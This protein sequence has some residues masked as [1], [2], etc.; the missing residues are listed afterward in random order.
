MR[1]NF[2]FL[3]FSLLLSLEAA[4]L[5]G[6]SEPA[7]IRLF[8]S[9]VEPSSMSADHYCTVVFSD[10]RFHSEKAVLHHGKDLDRKVF[11]GELSEEQWNGLASIL[12]NKDLRELKIPPYV[13]PLVMQETHPYSISIARDG[14]FQN[15]EFMDGKSLKPYQSQLKPLLQWWKTV[16]RQ[17]M[18]PSNA[19]KSERCL[20][21]NGRAVFAQ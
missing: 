6:K 19:P 11:E 2:L 4:A 12:D 10:H 8:L 17:K 14:H 20:L 15:F 16:R 5:D 7:S 18:E 9:E 13:P 1:I 3:S 21:D